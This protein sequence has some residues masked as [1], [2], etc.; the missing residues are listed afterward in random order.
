MPCTLDAFIAWNSRPA[1]ATERA[2][3]PT[4]S[5]VV[6]SG[7]TPSHGSSPSV[8]F[9]PTMPQAAA[10]MRIEPPVS[11]PTEPKHMPVEQRR[12]PSRRS[13]RPADRDGSTGWRTG[14]ERGLVA[15]RPER[16]LVQVGLA[17][18]DR[19]GLAQP[20]HDRRVGRRRSRAGTSE[21][22][23]VGVPR[24]VDEILH[25]DRNA[26]QR[27]AIP[28]G[29]NLAVGLGGVGERLRR[30][31]AAMNAFRSRRAVRPAR[32]QSRTSSIAEMLPASGSAAR[33]RQC[34]AAGEPL[35]MIASWSAARRPGG[36]AR[37]ARARRSAAVDARQ[38]F[39][40]RLQFGQPALLRVS[41]RSGEPGFDSHDQKRQ[42]AAQA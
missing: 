35:I 31:S 23:V 21:P 24:D 37:R 5:S 38:R 39:E 40:Q 33:R 8:G 16:E 17:D 11:V 41:D 30:A 15:G 13:I 22:A 34:C 26:V 12:P 28:A 4:W 1:S 3:G 25:R 36:L 18:D 7:T 10:G 20:P 19:A 32:A 9:R 2:S 14:A 27:A 42:R 6:L 29:G